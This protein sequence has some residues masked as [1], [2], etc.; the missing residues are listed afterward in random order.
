MDKTLPFSKTEIARL[1][2]DNKLTTPFHLYDETAIRQNVRRFMAAFAWAPG[3]KEY[4]AVK[5]NPAPLVLKMLAEEGC[6]ADCSSL[7]ELLIAER[8]GLAGHEVMFT[9]NNTPLAEFDKAIAVGARVNLDD[10][11]HIDYMV[12]AGLQLPDFM[13]LRYNPGPERTGNVFIGNP[14]EAKYGMTRDQLFEAYTRLRA[15]GVKSFGLHTMVASNEL[16][17]DYISQTAAM[18]FELARAVQDKVGINIDFINLGGGIG[19]PYRPEDRAMDIGA[20]SREIQGLYQASGLRVK[21]LSFECGRLI[22]GP[23]GYLITTAVHHKDTYKH[24]IG[25]D[26]CMADFMRPGV[27]GAYHHISVLGKESLPRDHVYDVTGSLCEN[28]DKFAINRN[29]PKIEPGDLLVLH[30]TGAH[31]QAMG[32]NYNGKLRCAQYLW[33]K[34][35]GSL[36][37]VRRADTMADYLGVFG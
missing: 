10:I 14:V 24:Y 31:G 20:L 22:T 37:C 4:F 12:K 29:L 13:C 19:I 6:G 34:E 18:M 23:Y 28:S 9:S 3:F 5:A 25:V 1:I 21:C 27:Y 2:T 33:N 16:N 17:P 26:A 15:M 35:Q 30:D 32:F 7:A 8:A 11:S 36:T